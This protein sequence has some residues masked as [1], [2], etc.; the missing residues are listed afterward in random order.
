MLVVNIAKTVAH[1]VIAEAT[2]LKIL[3]PIHP[4]LVVQAIMRQIL[5]P[6]VRG[7]QDIN[8]QLAAHPIT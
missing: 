2:A 6:T 8:V 7:L 1:R 5:V 3:V 4:P